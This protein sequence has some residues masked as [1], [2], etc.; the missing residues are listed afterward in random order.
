MSKRLFFISLVLCVSSGLAAL[1][2]HEILVLSTTVQGSTRPLR[3]MKSD[4]LPPSNPSLLIPNSSLL[5]AEALKQP[6]VVYYIDRYSNPSGIRWLNAIINNSRIYMPFIKSEIAK[7]NLPPELAYIPFIESEFIGN[8]RSRSGAVG[9]W[10]FMMN[11]IY[12]FDIKVNNIIDERKDFRK[13]T[14][15]A[16]LKFIDN[17]N[18]FNDWPM[19]LAAY[20]AGLGGVRRIAQQAKSNDYWVLSEKK[21]LKNETI[22][23]VPKLL[24]VSY[25]MERPRQFGLDY[26]PEAVEWTSIKLPRQISLDLLAAETG[27][28]RNLL[29]LLNMELL[30][31]LSPNDK[32]YELKVPAA[33]AEIIIEKLEDKDVVLLQYYRHEIRQGDTVYSI[34]RHY[35]I[36]QDLIEQHNPGI[37]RRYLKIGEVIRIPALN[38]ISPMQ[39]AQDSRAFN[40]SHVVKEG[41][42]LWALGR[43]YNVDIARLAAENNM[44]INQI[45][46]VGKILKVPIIE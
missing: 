10:Q 2:N 7:R 45:L 32:N 38:E 25:I 36:T 22:H 33:Q 21:L 13:S 44:Q 14:V 39:T 30:Q 16:L 34:S 23:Y 18:A 3:S 28:D 31:G 19:A 40:G 20:N 27:T 24:A 29:G 9:Y 42:T 15:A 5:S 35:G 12:P 43:L 41:E 46:S 11:S 6:L 1:D 8:A 37:L 26:W 17:Y 4:F